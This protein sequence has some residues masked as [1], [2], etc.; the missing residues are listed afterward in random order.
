MD[1]FEEDFLSAEDTTDAAAPQRRFLEHTGS[2][3]FAAVEFALEWES[4]AA[5]HTD[6]YVAGSLNLWRDYMPP[7]LETVLINQP[8][9]YASRQ[10]FLAGQLL[11][12]YVAADCVQVPRGKFNRRHRGPGE[13]VPL[14]GR[15]YPRRYI[16][17]VKG[18][19]SDDLQV[20]RLGAM[21]GDRM[22][23]ELNHPLAGKPLGLSTRILE[24]WAAVSEHGGRCNDVPEMIAGKGPGMQARWRNRPTDFFSGDAFTRS[25]AGADVEFYARARLVDHL[26]RVALRQVEKLY[27]RLLPPGGRILDLMS[28]WKSHL[29]GSY[30]SVTGL[31]LNAEELAANAVLS[32]RRL[33]D[34]NRQPVLPFDNG[35]F[36]GA[37]CTVSVEYLVRPFEV[38]AEVRRVLKEGAP[39]VVTFSNRWFPPKVIQVWEQVHQFE[40][41]GIVLEYFLQSGGWTDLQTFSLAGLPRPT[42]DKYADRMAYSD[43]VHAVWGYRGQ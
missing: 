29:A 35:A 4:A 24:A 9:G 13:V 18:I 38:F 37:V 16:A 11:A 25:A 26:D 42:D 22:T 21:E 41:P 5:R 30:T 32:E 36:D 1:G 17:E 40:R 19:T 31:G 8:V 43:P 15:F 10:R 7:E 12:D 28:S 2:R 14:A 33:Q 3:S 34:L 27:Q 6:I 23:V 20:F 39:F